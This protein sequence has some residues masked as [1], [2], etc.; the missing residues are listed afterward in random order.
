MS[1][2]KRHRPG[3]LTAYPKERDLIEHI[4]GRESKSTKIKHEKYCIFIIA[5]S[6]LVW[7]SVWPIFLRESLVGTGLSFAPLDWVSFS[8]S[9]RY[10]KIVRL[11]QAADAKY[12]VTGKVCVATGFGDVDE[13]GTLPAR[14]QEV[15]VNIADHAKCVDLYRPHNDVPDV[16]DSMICAGRLKG[17]YSTCT[18]DSG[19]PL[20]CKHEDPR[21]Y[22]LH[23]I[24]SWELGCAQP[25][26]YGVYASV[27]NLLELDKPKRCMKNS[28]VISWYLS[29]PMGSLYLYELCIVKFCLIQNK[30]NLPTISLSVLSAN[31]GKVAVYLSSDMNTK[32]KLTRKHSKLAVSPKRA[33]SGSLRGWITPC[34]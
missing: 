6:F 28:I 16:D 12:L 10:V 1:A 20:V 7:I 4:A 31:I 29:V 17:K 19:G 26:Q 25:H 22:Y 11:P 2:A 24:T 14:M 23:G 13:Q 3:K 9:C 34:I 18:G 15:R 30:S 8:L 33:S 21:T 5:Q 32:W 27:I